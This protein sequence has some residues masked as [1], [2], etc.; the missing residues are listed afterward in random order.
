MGR[1]AL[2]ISFLL[3]YYQMSTRS[4]HVQPYIKPILI[5]HSDF[6]YSPLK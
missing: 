1:D 5:S 2:N 6:V 3:Q 4:D